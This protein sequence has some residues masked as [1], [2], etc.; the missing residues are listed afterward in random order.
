MENLLFLY[1]DTVIDLAFLERIDSVL[2]R[3]SNADQ[4]KILSPLQPGVLSYELMR[5][6][7]RRR[8]LQACDSASDDREF[9]GSGD[10]NFLVVL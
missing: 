10:G 9:G 8:Y 2:H 4:N 3:C 6:S 5:A 7:K 1:A